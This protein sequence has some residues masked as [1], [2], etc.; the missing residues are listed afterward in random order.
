ME[1]FIRTHWDCVYWDLS[2]SQRCLFLPGEKLSKHILRAAYTKSMFSSARN[3]HL[4][5]TKGRNNKKK[6]YLRIPFFISC[7]CELKRTHIQTKCIMQR[8]RM[9]KNKERKKTI[10]INHNIKQNGFLFIVH[11]YALKLFSLLFFHFLRLS[12]L[13]SQLVSIWRKTSIKNRI[14]F[15]APL[16]GDRDKIHKMSQLLH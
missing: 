6:L 13:L 12:L 16:S 4:S 2:R 3:P 11:V 14:K 9:T 8:R 5:T 10:Q 7:V 15:I 1:F